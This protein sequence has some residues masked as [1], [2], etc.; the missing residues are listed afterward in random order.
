MYYLAREK[1]ERERVYG[2]GQFA[3]SQLSIA[4]DNSGANATSAVTPTDDKRTQ[5]KLSSTKPHHTA[6]AVAAGGATTRKDPVPSTKAKADYSMPLPRLPAP[7]TSHYSGM[8]YDTTAP[9]PTS[10][11]F[12]IP[13][14]PTPRARDTGAAGLPLAGGVVA[15]PASPV[16]AVGGFNANSNSDTTP[17]PTKHVEIDQS[18]TVGPKRGALPRAPP[19]STHRRSHSMSQ[20]PTTLTSRWGG[21]FTGHG[22]GTSGG[23]EETG[24]VFVSPDPP[25]TVAPEEDIEKE[26]HHEHT[27]PFAGGAT[28][29][30]KFGSILAGGPTDGGSRRQHGIGKRGTI[31]GVLTPS[32][33]LGGAG[34]S[35][36][37][38]GDGKD[39]NRTEDA[40]G[41]TI[42]FTPP[43][44]SMAGPA[45]AP[46]TPN[47]SARKS[48]VP[49]PLANVHRRAATILDPQG[50]MTRHER[51]SS[52]GTAI[53]G[54]TI[55][56][57]GAAAGG[58]GTIGRIRRPSTGTSGTGSTRPLAE[59]LFATNKVNEPVSAPAGQATMVEGDMAE[60]R[61]DEEDE[62]GAGY[63]GESTDREDDERAAVKPVFLKG[64]FRCVHI[65]TFSPT[66][67]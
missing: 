29:V 56:S 47:I 53:M 48:I 14:S 38:G 7:E 44:P 62:E 20:R 11:A 18:A 24:K 4:G 54:N 63:A 67:D 60:K 65:E 66:N 64:L 22:Q 52:T 58:G 34:T 61:E 27:S 8:S 21:M 37:G 5:H 23:V 57:G 40:A 25:K 39:E 49:Q 50:R 16:T 45:T 9:S 55:S 32:L 41:T 10:A 1:L 15:A 35:S 17:T 36:G 3:S 2:P 46:P 12:A 42:L 30:R 33:S 43:S 28:L 31:L 6:P 59:R 13:P 19:P 26:K 51:R